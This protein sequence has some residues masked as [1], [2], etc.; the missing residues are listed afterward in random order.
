MTKNIEKQTFLHTQQ[1]KVSENKNLFQEPIAYFFSEIFS[2]ISAD[3]QW[4]RLLNND[5]RYALATISNWKP[6]RL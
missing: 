4:Y 5:F 6:Y 1:D 3:C 2:L